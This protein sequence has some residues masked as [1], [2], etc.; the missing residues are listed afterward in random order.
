MLPAFASVSWAAPRNT[1]EECF[2][3]IAK[4]MYAVDENVSVPTF[5]QLALK[6][7]LGTWLTQ[8]SLRDLA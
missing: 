7:T 4:Y 8:A 2:P 5:K 6:A 1:T 3:K